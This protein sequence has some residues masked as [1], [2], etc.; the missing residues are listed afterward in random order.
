MK[1]PIRFLLAAALTVN[2]SFT[3]RAEPSGPGPVK[4][5]FFYSQS[6]E[7][8]K[9]LKNN[10]LPAMVDRYKSA[11]EINFLEIG[12]INNYNTLTKME[13]QHSV[14]AKNPPPTIFVENVL[15][16]GYGEIR[17]DFESVARGFIRQAQECPVAEVAKPSSQE[18]K[19]IKPVVKI[20]KAAPVRV[21]PAKQDSSNTATAAVEEKFNLL[22][23]AAVTGAGLLDGVNPCAFSTVIMLVLYL[24]FTGY[25]KAEVLK[26]GL[27]F[28]AGVFIAYLLIGLGL[29]EFARQAK[30]VPGL[31]RAINLLF[32][33]IAIVFGFLSLYDYFKIRQGK[34]KEISLQLPDKIKN[35]IKTLIWKKSGGSR[36]LATSFSIGFFI[37]ILE[38]PCTGQVY[39]PIVLAIRELPNLRLHA[40]A[41]LVYYNLMFI[42]PLLAVFA[43]VYLGTTSEKL[44]KFLEQR[45]GTVKLLTSALFFALAGIL[46]YFR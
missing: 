20:Q 34:L 9:D 16:D 4:I 29:L 8:C 10:F 24:T 19:Q 43:L 23:F 7:E 31:S 39:F 6:C 25:K 33:A 3:A 46:A 41:Y 36:H 44:V 35:K 14:A 45:S 40:I 32:A 18:K 28:A 42:L 11:I 37:G 13:K 26:A 30:A 17:R 12:D 21:E 38:F 27:A 1:A 2:F 22:G 5:F 15:L